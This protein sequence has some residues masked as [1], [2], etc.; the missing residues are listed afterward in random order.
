MTT[1]ADQLKSYQNYLVLLAELLRMS[2]RPGS[3]PHRSWLHIS[4]TDDLMKI[5]DLCHQVIQ[6]HG[7]H[8]P[9]KK[10]IWMFVWCLVDNTCKYQD[11]EINPHFPDDGEH[12][13]SSVFP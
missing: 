2:P 6:R 10:V 11:C 9:Q 1:H 8:H 5:V 3:S 12:C 13:K 7:T 4:L